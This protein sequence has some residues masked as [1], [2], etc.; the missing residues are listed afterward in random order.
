MSIDF[1]KFLSWAES[2][3]D[4]IAVKGDEILVN[5]IFCEDRKHHLWCNPSGGKNKIENGVYHCW[6]S[7]QKGSLLKLVMLV[8]KCSYEQAVDTMGAS[9]GGSLENLERQIHE[10]FSSKDN[11]EESH[12]P[13]EKGSL[14]VPSGCYLFDDLPS[15]NHLKNQS[16]EY[17]QGRKIS[18][19][20]LFVCTSGRYKNRIVIPYYDKKGSLIY[21]NGRYVGDPGSNLRYLGPPKELGIGKGDVL[22]VQ[23][24][25]TKGEK[26]YITEGEFDAI[27]LSQCGFYSA[28]LGGKSLTE[29]QLRM[30]DGYIPVLCLDADEA[31]SQALP[32]MA[33]FLFSRGI[34][35]VHYVRPCKEYKDWNGL[36]VAKGEKILRGYVNMQEKQYNSSL[37][38]GDWE[39]TKI[40]INSI[41]G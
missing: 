34:K 16:L 40:A 11:S 17:L 28:A 38:G 30:I 41:I 10:F 23:K 4:D 24:W 13:E 35:R 1:D 5:S 37:G 6:K 14:E 33:N 15:S 25:P 9:S 20:G 26:I 3:F 29:N 18:P 21:Y 2:R 8:D 12:E 22:Y 36:L 31:G 39:S 27:S 7:D 19:D 32:K